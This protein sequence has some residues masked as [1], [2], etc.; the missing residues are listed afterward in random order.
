MMRLVEGGGG[1][2]GSGGRGGTGAEGGGSKGWQLVVA[3]QVTP[4]SASPSSLWQ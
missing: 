2:A 1:A 4:W 3:V